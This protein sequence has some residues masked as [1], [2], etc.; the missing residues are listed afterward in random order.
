MSVSLEDYKAQL[1]SNYGFVHKV[2]LQEI[3]KKWYSRVRLHPCLV[4]CG[5]GRFTCGMQDVQ[6]FIDIIEKEGS[7]YIRDV[8][9]QQ[10]DLLGTQDYGG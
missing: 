8:S 1:K 5:C 4:R 3:L 9:I 7:D 2:Q 6:H 10:V